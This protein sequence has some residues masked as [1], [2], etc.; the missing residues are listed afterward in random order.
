MI[1]V[2]QPGRMATTCFSHLSVT[3]LLSSGGDVSDFHS[4]LKKRQLHVQIAV[5]MA[6]K[7][8]MREIHCGN[9]LILH[10]SPG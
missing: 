2:Q 10:T 7:A 3:L 6:P 1:Y 8:N 9:G 5:H 4:S